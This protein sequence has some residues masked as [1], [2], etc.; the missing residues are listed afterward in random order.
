[1][2][3]GRTPLP[4]PVHKFCRKRT[5]A[6]RKPTAGVVRTRCHSATR[7][8]RGHLDTLDLGPQSEGRRDNERPLR[9]LDDRRQPG[10]WSDSPEGYARHSESP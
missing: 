3:G 1:M 6:G 4:G 2:A 5:P 9:V 10:G 7:V 8:L